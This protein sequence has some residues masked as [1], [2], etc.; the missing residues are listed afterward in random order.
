VP[1]RTSF[2]I[3]AGAMAVLAAS[4]AFAPETVDLPAHANRRPE[5]FALRPGARA[6]FAGASAVGFFALALLGLFSSLGGIIVRTQIHTTSTAVLGLVPFAAFAASAVAQTALERLSHTRLLAAGAVL[7]PMG[8]ALITL[9]LYRPSLWLLLV[10]AGLAGGGAGALFKGGV[11]ETVRSAEPASRAGVLAN[12]FVIA[13]LGMGLPSIALSLVIPHTGLRPSLIGYASILAI[14][15]VTA[16]V[17][18]VRTQRA[19]SP[20]L[21]AASSGLGEEALAGE[22]SEAASGDVDGRV[23]GGHA[24]EFVQF[25]DSECLVGVLVE[26]VHDGLVGGGLFGW[27]GF[28]CGRREFGDDLPGGGQLREAGFGLGEGGGEVLDPVA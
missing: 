19:L 11:S 8:L 2:L 17:A 16:V 27:I 20:F 25:A 26:G 22:A 7:F 15:A 9:S 18:A 1:L 4:V 13:Y 24:E 14:G 5:R 6:S 10:A 28:A 3:L 12:F 23:V 21:I